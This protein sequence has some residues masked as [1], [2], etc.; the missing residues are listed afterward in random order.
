VGI[1]WCVLEHTGARRLLVEHCA[2][3]TAEEYGD[4]LTFGPGHYDV[5]ERW[6]R[7]GGSSFSSASIVR[8]HEDEEWPRGRVVFDRSAD[9]FF[10]YCDGRIRTGGLVPE[11]ISLFRLPV[12]RVVVRGD[13][14]Y[15]SS[16]SIRGAVQNPR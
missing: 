5:R 11:L 13:S 4:C 12:D 8:S 16:L 15:Q 6:Q 2:L 10:L 14:H 3:D 9:R 7:T 1:F